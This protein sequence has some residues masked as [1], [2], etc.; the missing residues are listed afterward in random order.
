MYFTTVEREK[1]REQRRKGEEKEKGYPCKTQLHK[2]R[3]IKSPLLC[4]A[5]NPKRAQFKGSEETPS[6]AGKR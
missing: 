4:C 6:L 3:D 5:E 1:E 2:S